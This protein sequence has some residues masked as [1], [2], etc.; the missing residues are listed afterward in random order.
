MGALMLMAELDARFGVE[1][2]PETSRAMASVED[3]LAFMR[4]RGVLAG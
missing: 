2:D 4:L 3:A 1:L